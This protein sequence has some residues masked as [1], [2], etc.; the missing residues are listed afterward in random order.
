MNSTAES[1]TDRLKRAQDEAQVVLVIDGRPK[2]VAMNET[3]PPESHWQGGKELDRFL[4]EGTWRTDGPGFT[5]L[6]EWVELHWGS[7]G[8][9]QPPEGTAATAD[10]WGLQSQ[11][12]LDAAT[13]TRKLIAAAKLYGQEQVGHHATAFATHGMIE[14]TCIYLLKGPPMGAAKPLDEYCTLLPHSEALERIGARTDPADST[15]AWPGRESESLCALES[16]YFEGVSPLD[17]EPGRYATPLLKDGVD[18]LVLLLGL[19]WGSSFR[20]IGYWRGVHPVA[21]A[22]LPYRGVTAGS[23]AGTWYAELPL[24]GYGAPIRE[25]PL[26]TEELRHLVTK[27]A[28]HPEEVRNRLRR[29]MEHVRK[30]AEQADAGHKVFD[31]GA[32]LSILFTEGSDRDELSSVISR[33]AAWYFS[34]SETER[35]RTEAMLSEFYALQS[36][37]LRGRGFDWTG[38]EDRYR[39]AE[40]LT[41]ADIV[42]RTSLKSLIAEGW[43]KDWGEAA[44]ASTL[45]FDPPRAESEVPSVKSDSLTWSIEEQRE[46]DQALEGI[47][48]PVIETAPLPPT[49]VGPSTVV[50]ALSDLVERYRA[51]GTPYVIPHPARLYLAHPKWPQTESE[52]LDD[53]A[54][55]YC[56]RDVQRHLQL[57]KDAAARKGLVQLEV[58]HDPDMYH[59]RRREE[60][61]QPFL[62]SHE[63]GAAVPAPGDETIRAEIAASQRSIQGTSGSRGQSSAVEADPADPPSVLPQSVRAGLGREWQRLWLGFQNDVNFVTDSLLHLLDGIHAKHLTERQRLTQVLAN[64]G[65]ALKTLDDAVRAAGD[66]FTRPGYPS[67]RAFLELRGEPLYLRTAPGGPMEQMA[68]KGWVAEVWDLWESQYR[69]QLAH[70]NR[71][72]PGAIPPRQ[73]VLGDLRHIRNN[74]LHNGIAKRREAASCEV[75]RWFSEGEAIHIRLRHVLDFFN[76]MGWLNENSFIQGEEGRASTWHIDRE[77]RPSEP[78]PALVSVRPVVDPLEQDSRYRYGAGAAFEDGVFGTTPMGPESRESDAQV[79]DRTR[80]WLKMTVNER[81]NIE[82]PELGPVSAA[83]LYRGYMEGKQHSRRGIWGP[84]VEFRE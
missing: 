41:D 34:D 7:T 66:G 35:Q 39:H 33:R 70:D 54:G 13:A 25:R 16:R 75:L 20:R 44:T 29:A 67:L 15:I 49:Q 30:S 18:Q 19:V 81:G 5:E 71:E 78:V 76:Q 47:W 23:G 59:P 38:A 50:G 22:A 37:V 36:N 31:I 48:K 2:I 10:Q 12:P 55:Y 21:V 11:A 83:T 6:R 46:I 72:V 53:R 84:W 60:W 4:D 69:T 57:W 28:E 73:Q 14:V 8:E 51:Q 42:L 3:T 58:P 32:A 1:I 40:L 64:S 9:T 45:R 56:A 63:E 24:Q 17:E 65:G 43:P 74:F 52:P 62:S 80:K 27:L 61:P 26:A 79:K 82:V 77:G 68:F